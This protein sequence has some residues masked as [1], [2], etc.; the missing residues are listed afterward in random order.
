MLFR[1][2]VIAIVE[3][4]TRLD[5]RDVPGSPLPNKARTTDDLSQG[6][7]SKRR[8]KAI[9]AQSVSAM[10]GGNNAQVDTLNQMASPLTAATIRSPVC[11][12]SSRY[13]NCHMHVITCC[14]IAG[15]RNVDHAIVLYLVILF[16]ICYR[17]LAKGMSWYVP[18]FIHESA[19]KQTYS[20]AVTFFPP[21]TSDVYL[22]QVCTC[23]ILM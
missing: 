13:A 17:D 23:V 9:R 16:D 7:Q 22:V 10:P 11:K 18:T 20:N 4:N 14:S 3:I 8:A 21:C 6:S 2:C 15:N 1:K 5:W 19:T 12:L